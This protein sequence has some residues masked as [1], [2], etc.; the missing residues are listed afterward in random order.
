MTDAQEA[1][2]VIDDA[3]V[4]TTTNAGA[5]I[6]PGDADE[7]ALAA[8]TGA[9]LVAVPFPA[10]ADGRGFSVAQRLRCLGFTGRLRA[11]GHVIPD[12][13]AYARACG[14]DEVAVTPAHFARTGGEAAWRSAVLAATPPFKRRRAARG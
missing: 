12:Q 9:A 6:V 8:A 4:T 11:T 3:G 13:F 10:F 5:L 14:F 7:A 1:L 2:T